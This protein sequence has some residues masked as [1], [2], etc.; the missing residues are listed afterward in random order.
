MSIQ[1]LDIVLY[2]RQGERR[3]L[4]LRPGVVN[5]ITGDSKTGK[6]AL[7]N[8]VDYCLGSSS[9]AVPEG[10]IRNNVSWYGLRLTDG[11]AEHFIARRAPDLGRTTTSDAYYAVGS[12]VAIPTADVLSVT[13]NIGT[14]IE[15]LR[16]VVG[17]ELN[18]HEPAEGQT[19]PPLTTTLRHA[20]A[21]VFQPQNE[22]SQPGFLFHGQ[23]DNFTAQ[24][25]KDTLPYFLGV[26]DDD[27]VTGK[28]TLKELRRLL[29]EKERILARREAVAIGGLSDAAA[30]L[31]EARDT[32]LI[33]LDI[34][35]DSWEDAIEVLHTA[36]NASPEE[37][38]TR[39][40]ESTD[41]AEL[42]RL[43]EERAELK[44]QLALQ[45]GD[46]DAMRALLTDESLFAHESTE[47]VSRMRSLQ[48]FSSSEEPCC[49]LCD[50]PTNNIIPSSEILEAEIQRASE[51]LERVTRHTPGLEALIIE[52]EQRVNTTKNLLQDNR[53]ALEAL[54]R[55]DERLMEL[56]DASSRRAYVIGR[57]SLFLETL[58]EIA[59]DSELRAEISTLQQEVEQLES[60]LS[61]ENFQ[62]RLDSIL[63][64]LSRDLTQWAEHL[65]LEHQGNPFRLDLRHLQI[66]A[67]AN[68]GPI[69]MDRMGSG[70]NWLG[71]HLIA[72][73]ALHKWF[74]RMSKPVPRFLFLDQPSQ[75]YFPPEQ[76]SDGS[77]TNLDNADRLAVIQLFELIRNIVE[78]LSPNLQVI[79]TEHADITEDWYQTSVIER[80]RNGNALIPTDW[81]SSQN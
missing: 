56:R 35:P 59:N 11:L 54:Q 34:V 43:N 14:I 7:I 67:D 55:A 8:V 2:S 28:A 79:I 18:V 63:S 19:R 9:C 5:I 61:A 58:P 23:S 29:R 51:Q 47:Q 73:L 66:V 68:T 13:T 81:I 1:I 32:G 38:L 49:P 75:V 44:Q 25:I 60:D 72:H 16:S 41:Q 36:V 53:T 33:T 64:V 78:E 30:L 37:Q 76:D 80:W 6:S 42:L 57:I 52:Q 17:I 20:L 31:S 45:Q 4:S 27:Y 21:F 15:R 50:Q 77:L 46:L 69:R 62:E 48:L 39:Y 10:V 12:T 3:L 26:V 40:E 24:A 22:I 70:A 71:C 65:D 74:V